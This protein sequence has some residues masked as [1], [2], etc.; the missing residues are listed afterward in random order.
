MT[1]EA[2]KESEPEGF[3]LKKCHY[4]IGGF[5]L[6]VLLF[7]VIIIAVSLSSKNKKKKSPKPSKTPAAK[8]N[9]ETIRQLI[10]KPKTKIEV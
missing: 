1:T 8:P 9:D 4:I 10:P 2:P 7:A 5:V 3:K 6:L